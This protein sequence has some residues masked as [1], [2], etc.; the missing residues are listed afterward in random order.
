MTLQTPNYNNPINNNNFQKKRPLSISSRGSIGL[1]RNSY[2]SRGLS[3]VDTNSNYK[4][5]SVNLRNRSLGI[6][7]R[8][9]IKNMKFKKKAPSKKLLVKKSK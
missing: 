7:N 8:Q 6:K 3:Q 9:S 4:V 2:C 5:N 1:S